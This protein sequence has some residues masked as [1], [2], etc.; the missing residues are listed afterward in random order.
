MHLLVQ[1]LPVEVLLEELLHFRDACR[2]TDQDDLVD[3]TLLHVS[4]FEGL[5]AKRDTPFKGLF[6]KLLEFVPR[7]VQL[8]ILVLSERLD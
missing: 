6:A 1:C 4:V 7:Q 3:L 5:S 2:P 8:E